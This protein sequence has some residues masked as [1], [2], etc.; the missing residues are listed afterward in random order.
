M[1]MKRQA[2]TL[3][4]VLVIAG[5]LI[6]AAALPAAGAPRPAG[7]G[8]GSDAKARQVVALARQSLQ[9]NGLKAVLLRVNVGR[10]KLVSTGLGESMAG[11]PATPRMHFRIGAM[12]I[13]S[14]ITIL[15]QLQEAGRL[16]L[17]D[18]LSRWFPSLPNADRVTLRMM[19][20]STS[21]YYDYLQGDPTFEDVLFSDVFRQWKP[22]ELLDYAFARGLACE[23][24]ACFTYA[25]TNYVLIAEVLRE[26]TGRPV[27]RLMRRRIFRPLGLRN[28]FISPKPSIKPPVLHAYTVDRGPYED[29]TFWSPSWTV[30][31]GTIQTSNPHDIARLARAIGTGELISRRSRHEMFAPDTAGYPGFSS[32][33]YFGLGVNVVGSWAFQNPVINGYTGIMAYLPQKKISIAIAVTK[34]EAAAETGRNYAQAL[35]NEIGTYLAPEYPANVPG[36]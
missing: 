27:A 10:R 25:H 5:A 7:S 22:D 23:A 3:G 34:K 18:K 13:P 8:A 21:G 4:V 17:D 32:E 20:N 26:V 6:A 9:E 14:L 36:S 29:S 35:F 16:S 28:T 19:A 12:A 24:G 33:L 15:L 11:V 30:G 31:R 1:G 2:L